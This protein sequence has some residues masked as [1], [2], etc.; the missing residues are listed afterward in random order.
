M[1]LAKSEKNPSTT[2]GVRLATADNASSVILLADSENL[3]VDGKSYVPKVGQDSGS[4]I[5]TGST[6]LTS[7]A[8]RHNLHMNI[9]FIDGHVS[10]RRRIVDNDKTSHPENIR[11][12][13]SGTLTGTRNP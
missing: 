8:T 11:W 12:L 1:H 3:S 4:T 2:P 10:P 7:L 9:L 5:I 6:R 13:P